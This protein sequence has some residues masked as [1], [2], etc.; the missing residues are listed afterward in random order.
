MAGAF[1]V[2]GAGPLELDADSLSLLSWDILLVS[3]GLV[4]KVL[5]SSTSVEVGISRLVGSVMMSRRLIESRYQPSDKN[6]STLGCESRDEQSGGDQE[7]HVESDSEERVRGD[8]IRLAAMPLGHGSSAGSDLPLAWM[9][10]TADGTQTRHFQVGIYVAILEPSTP[11]CRSQAR[12]LSLSS[13]LNSRGLQIPSQGNCFRRHPAALFPEASSTKEVPALKID[14]LR[15]PH[16][17]TLRI[18]N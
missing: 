10:P 9:P 2:F 18:P 6:V 7:F 1:E 14:T 5:D 13:H 12:N 8:F 17:K 3:V 11:V 4:E 15:H 16:R